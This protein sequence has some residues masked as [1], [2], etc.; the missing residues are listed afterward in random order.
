MV[1][2]VTKRRQDGEARSSVNLQ[3]YGKDLARISRFSTTLT[4]GAEVHSGSAALGHT[5]HLIITWPTSL[6]LEDEWRRRGQA[7]GIAGGKDDCWEGR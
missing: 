3:H 1:Q 2:L 5:N 6:S 7:I 4:V